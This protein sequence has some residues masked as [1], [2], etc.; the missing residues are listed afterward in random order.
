MLLTVPN[1]SEGADAAVLD[2][3]VEATRPL[4]LLDLH[5]D[6]DHGRSVLTLAGRQ[7]DV[8]PAL[9]RLAAVAAELID[10]TAHPG[11]HPHVGSLDVAPVVHLD[12]A[13]RGAACA[14]ALTAGALIGADAGVPV[15]LYGAL[16]TAPERVERAALRAGG[17]AAL[18]ERIAAGDLRP[19]Y[20]PARV[21]PR[22]GATLVTARPPLVAFNVDL[23]TD[24]V[25]LARRIAARLRESGGGPAGV[26]AIGLALPAR[27]RAQ[28]SFNVHDHRAAPLR[29]LV[30]AV[31]AAAPVAEAELV[32]LAPAAA[33][34]GFPADVPL[35]DFDP[36]RH[37]IENALRSV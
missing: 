35:R 1:V 4:R 32:G 7:G 37:L 26:R 9:A 15:F 31:R 20:G 5:S 13:R 16:A 21:H 8:A 29:D 19:D 11:S 3:L 17:P 18:A 23:A 30:A 34:D 2:Q 22:G 24:D 25:E 14:A 28:V 10:V 33:F 6:P 27:G 36:G 12:A